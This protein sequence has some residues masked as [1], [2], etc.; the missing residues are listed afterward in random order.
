MSTLPDASHPVARSSVGSRT[1]RFDAL[2]RGIVGRLGRTQLV[3]LAACGMAG[4]TSVLSHR[5]V[6][7]TVVV[8]TVG[9]AVTIPERG[10]MP[11]VGWLPVWVRWFV[12]DRRRRRWYRPLHLTTAG[13]HVD[14]PSLPRW[15][16][17]L[18]LVGHPTDGYGIVHDT[19]A[20]TMTVVVPVAGRG[21][22]TRAESQREFLVEGWGRV[23]AA[24][25][26]DQTGVQ[27]TRICWS[28][29]ARPTALDAHA[30][31]V[32]EQA[33]ADTPA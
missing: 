33:G 17:G 22:T 7:V 21:F 16:G 19:D 6:P 25:A 26:A 31:W 1:Y 3:V 28:D 4:F 32:T 29:I 5:Y 24:F 2:D 27:V 12:R 8:L 20:G 18:R 15:L 9:L 13:L 11:V 14:Q 30:H 10:G 23:F